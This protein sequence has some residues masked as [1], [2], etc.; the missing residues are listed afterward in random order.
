MRRPI[1]L[2]VMFPFCARRFRLVGAGVLG[3][4]VLGAGVSGRGWRGMSYGASCHLSTNSC[5]Y[6]GSRVPRFS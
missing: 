1:I 4:G 2:T 3:A 5:I 6:L